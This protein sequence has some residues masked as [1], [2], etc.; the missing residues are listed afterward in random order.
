VLRRLTGCERTW[1]SAFDGY[2]SP[3]EQPPPSSWAGPWGA[4]V[5]PSRIRWL[6][7]A[8]TRFV[9]TV[10]RCN[11]EPPPRREAHCA[12]LDPARREQFPQTT[13]W[14]RQSVLCAGD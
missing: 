1:R 2:L 3:R 6:D 10:L 7:A 13:G 14:L 8:V 12:N 4:W 5:L 11:L 9:D